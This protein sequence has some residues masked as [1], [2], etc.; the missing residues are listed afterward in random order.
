MPV[1]LLTVLISLGVDLA[2]YHWSSFRGR[3][4]ATDVLVTDPR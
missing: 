4:S 3:A 2:R 1:L